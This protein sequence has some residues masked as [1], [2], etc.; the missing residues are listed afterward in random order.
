AWSTG[1]NRSGGKATRTR[2]ASRGG[3]LRTLLM[4]SSIGIIQPGSMLA[5]RLVAQA[6]GRVIP[7][8]D[9]TPMR[10]QEP[11][12]VVSVDFK[13]P[14]ARLSSPAHVLTILTLTRQIASFLR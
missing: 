3:A 7:V 14:G 9:H 12:S 11:V 13:T 2:A 10:S 8:R 1:S 5:S 4:S 6:D